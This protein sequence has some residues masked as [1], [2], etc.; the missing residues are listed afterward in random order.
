MN[1]TQEN[2]DMLKKLWADGL[3]ASQIAGK[4]GGVTR[5]AVIGKV[6]R[7]GL[8]G[9]ATTSRIRNYGSRSGIALFP[10][11]SSNAPRR[12]KLGTADLKV[13]L[14][15]GSAQPP[16]AIPLAP[17]PEIEPFDFRR[18]IKLD[19]LKGSHCRWPYGDPKDADFGF[20]GCT[21][22]QGS[23]YCPAHRAVAF[24]TVRRRRPRPHREFISVGAAI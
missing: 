6:H 23:S 19:D 11:R 2:T 10:T 8:A 9:R 24:N 21:R 22:A 1:W 3:S 15:P 16:L 14:Q 17:P 5:N 7:L 18:L 12:L 20:C 13:A 4:V